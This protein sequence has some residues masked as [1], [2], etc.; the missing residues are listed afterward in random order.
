[1]SIAATSSQDIE[2]KRK[3]AWQGDIPPSHNWPGAVDVGR[4]EMIHIRAHFT[5]RDGKEEM[6][7]L[8]I[9]GEDFI[10]M[11]YAQVAVQEMAC[12]VR[13]VEARR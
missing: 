11:H 13:S 5:G 12:A 1:M 8:G 6:L 7:V 9:T 2:V 10:Q 4:D 3:K